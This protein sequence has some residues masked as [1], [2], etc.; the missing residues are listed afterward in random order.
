MGFFLF[1]SLSRLGIK[2][3]NYGR[4]FEHIFFI[5]RFRF[6]F[7]IFIQKYSHSLHTSLVCMLL[8]MIFMPK[9]PPDS[10]NI[11]KFH[12]AVGYYLCLFSLSLVFFASACASFLMKFHRY[13]ETSWFLEIQMFRVYV[14]RHHW[15]K[16]KSQTFL[17]D[18]DQ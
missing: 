10:I 12:A 5:I 13:D 18:F 16:N 3:N 14:A 7:Q 6:L 1:L 11:I 15:N 4:E 2:Y 8:W 17:Y 9:F